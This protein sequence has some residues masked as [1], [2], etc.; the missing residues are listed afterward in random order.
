MKC[1]LT[2]VDLAVTDHNAAT[3]VRIYATLYPTSMYH[4][5]D[6]C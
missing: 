6:Q 2:A 3:E 5:N 4:A 1:G